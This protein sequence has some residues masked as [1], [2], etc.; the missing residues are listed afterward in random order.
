MSATPK[1]GGGRA[2]VD[3]SV[4]VPAYNEKD[5]LA[6]TLDS[7]ISHLSA[8]EAAA[9]WEVIVVD[10]GSTDGTAD[11]VADVT[12]RDAR[13]QLVSGGP[14]NR[15]KGHALRLGVLA[16]HGRRV[17]LTDADLAAPIDEL[18]RLDKALSDGH[19]AAIG[20]REAPGASIERHQHRLRETLGRAGNLLI[21]GVAVPG[22]RDTQCGFKLFDGDR[23]REAFA[24]S[25]LDG[26]GI[27]VEIL[28]YFRRSGWPVVEVPVRW[29]HQPG[30]KIR[31]SDYARVLGEL[32][33][34]RVRSVRPADAFAVAVAVFLLMAVA[35]HIGRRL[36]PNGRCLPDS[37]Q[38]QSQ[39]EWFLAVTAD[40]LAHL[41]TPS[42]PPARA[43]RRREPDD[44]GSM[45]ITL[46]LLPIAPATVI[47][48]NWRARAEKD[49]AYWRASALVPR[50]QPYDEQRRE[51]VDKLVGRPG[52]W[53]G[54]VGMG[55][56][57]RGPKARSATTLP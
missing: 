17:L 37:L 19:T 18:E 23:A 44:V 20:S 31:P 14:H 21:R 46:A 39:W 38:D 11:V 16:S 36:D 45:P 6:P 41:R 49:F 40:N 51:E 54:G 52:K 27:D 32:A 12:A 13:V 55:P 34:L 43:S 25:R 2:S 57:R 24:V 1:A 33:V 50:P 53:V 26:F 8:T 10:D 29:S 4:V 48:V 35:L 30:S 7:I 5:R 15:G 42:S 56:A 22:I 28:R 9:R 47:G 3:L